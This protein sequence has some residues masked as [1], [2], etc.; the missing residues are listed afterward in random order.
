MRGFD[1][2]EIEINRIEEA[3]RNGTPTEIE[4]M[5]HIEEPTLASE[6][7]SLLREATV[8]K[9]ARRF[10][11]ACEKLRQA[12]A[13]PGA[14]NLMIEDRLRLPMYLQLAGRNDD[15]WDELNRLATQ[16]T[17]PF[18]QPRIAHQRTVFLRK[19]NNESATNPVRAFTLSEEERQGKASSDASKGVIPSEPMP[20]FASD[21]C[22]LRFHATLELRTPLRVIRRHGEQYL[23]TDG[24]QPRIAQE[25]WEGVWV[26]VTKTWRELSGVDIP[27]FGLS[28]ASDVGPLMSANYLPFLI[29]VREAVESDGTI[30]QR[31]ETLEAMRVD[32]RWSE[33]FAQHGGI[34]N[35]VARFFPA[36]LDTLPT[37]TADAAEELLKL[38]LDTRNKLAGAPDE[39][40]LAVKG[41]GPA[42]LRAIRAYCMTVT[43]NRDDCRMDRV[44]R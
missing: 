5:L 3:L 17:D 19:E 30:A 33:Y 21:L 26:R 14:E 7:Y 34:A 31:I 28:E 32:D 23:S 11:D 39:T 25:P 41:I 2:A 44:L 9:R 18:S 35:I 27:E 24:M 8:L 42:K 43:N 37:L 12:Y 20:I 22:K 10:L 6:A 15:G 36:F 38:G 29:A 40:L 13:A 1:E 4:G 16:Y